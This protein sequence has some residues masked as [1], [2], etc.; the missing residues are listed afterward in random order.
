ML[1]IKWTQ[2]GCYEPLLFG[3]LHE[4]CDSL[5]VESVEHELKEKGEEVRALETQ[6]SNLLANSSNNETIEQLKKAL[7][8]KNKQLEKSVDMFLCHVNK[9]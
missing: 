6:L 5:Q 2:L 8:D 9:I 1:E 7:D 3:H 4:C